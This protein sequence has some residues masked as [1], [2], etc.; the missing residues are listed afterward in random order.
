MATNLLIGSCQFRIRQARK[1]LKYLSYLIGFAN[2]PFDIQ[3]VPQVYLIVKYNVLVDY[4][5]CFYLGIHQIDCS[6]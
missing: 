2:K 5:M 6:R 3:N 4:F 1:S